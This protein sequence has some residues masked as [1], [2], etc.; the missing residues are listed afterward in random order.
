[1]FDSCDSPV[2]TVDNCLRPCVRLTG[3]T[4]G[5]NPFSDTDPMPVIANDT[6]GEPM[7][8]QVNENPENFRATARKMD[9][10]C[11]HK[12]VERGDSTFTLVGRDRSTPRTICFWI[13][14]NI[15]TCPAEKLVDALQDALLARSNPNR[16]PAD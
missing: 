7:V 1:M 14:E 11:F 13:M 3:H 9:G 15:E 6:K 10:T 5:H 8:K 12:A 4:G 2:R 16:R